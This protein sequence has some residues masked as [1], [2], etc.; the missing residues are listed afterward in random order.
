MSMKARLTKWKSNN[1]IKLFR[2]ENGLSQQDLAAMIGVSTYTLQRWE[3][4][5][6]SPT[7]GNLDI[8]NE[9]IEGIEGKLQD[10]K[11]ERP[12]YND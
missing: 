11:S 5:T 3:G 4:G 8:L 7:N 1:P 10:W 9:I 12:S 6:V 2:K